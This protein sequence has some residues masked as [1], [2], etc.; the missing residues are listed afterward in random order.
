LRKLPCGVVGCAAECDRGRLEDAAGRG[1][2]GIL[3]DP[4]GDGVEVAGVDAGTNVLN[5]G[6]GYWLT[7]GATAIGDGLAAGVDAGE[8]SGARDGFGPCEEVVGLF[9][10]Q[11]SALFLVE[12]E[13]GAGGEALA[14]G[15]GDGGG[16]VG[17]GERG[18]GAVAKG[19]VGQF[20]V[21]AAV[22][23]DEEAEAGAEERFALA[24]PGVVGSAGRVGEPVSGEGEA[25]A[26]V[27]EGGVA[28]VVVAVESE[29]GGGGG[30]G[31]L[32]GCLG[33]GRGGGEK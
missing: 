21:E 33:E 2:A 32:G 1:R 31:C 5:C 8:I 4:E 6:D 7:V 22:G 14:D 27:G 15:G 28:G 18:G 10:E 12:E 11:A 20:G 19:C 13:D 3:G 16:G 29:I 26:Q 9:G 30:W 23:D 25:L 24:E 17:V